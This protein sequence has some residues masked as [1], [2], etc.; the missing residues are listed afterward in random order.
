MK[1]FSRVRRQ[2]VRA[3]RGLCFYCR[4]PMW[5]DC[6]ERFVRQYGLRGA[7]VHWL[8]A[9]AEHMYARCRDGADQP[10]N[11]VAA[12]RYCNSRRHRTPYPLPLGD[13]AR[14]AK[15]R[16]TAG[17]SPGCDLNTIADFVFVHTPKVWAWVNALICADRL[18][19]PAQITTKAKLAFGWAL[20][21]FAAFPTTALDPPHRAASPAVPA[22]TGS[23]SPS[24][25]LLQVS[26]LLKFVRQIGVVLGKVTHHQGIAQ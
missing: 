3:Q 6:P 14:K 21:G 9:T 25:R 1:P 2:Q 10:G 20:C 15:Q 12:C 5:Q 23:G 19:R 18:C 13:Y 26:D 11:I 7:R 17:K 24:C 22:L 4:Q 8:Q 16:L